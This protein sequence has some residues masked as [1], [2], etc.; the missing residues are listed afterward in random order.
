MAKWI[1]PVRPT[2]N[3]ADSL[4]RGCLFALAVGWPRGAR[5]PI[6]GTLAETDDQNRSRGN[7]L[8]SIE[9]SHWDITDAGWML[10]S[11][12][13][14]DERFTW[15]DIGGRLAITHSFTAAVLTRPSAVDLGGSAFS[16]VFAKVLGN[17]ISTDRSWIINQDSTGAVANNWRGQFRDVGL[18]DHVV[19]SGVVPST[20]RTDMIIL[21]YDR[22][23][24]SLQIWINGILRGSLAVSAAVQNNSAFLL[25]VARP[26]VSESEWK[27]GMLGLWERAITNSEIMRLMSDP[28]RMW[29]R[30][31][32]LLAPAAG[33]QTFFLSF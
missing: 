27:V 2:P 20:T 24:G 4:W 32:Q 26:Q 3:R 13:A 15:T 5:G 12:G 14:S 16:G 11:D 18:V 7:F 22:T 9:S 21:R 31:A 6:P 10:D 33:V 8:S 19:D 30:S 29:K 23:A 17:T 1:K 25:S 28:F